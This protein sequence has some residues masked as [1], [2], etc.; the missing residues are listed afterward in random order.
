V[1]GGSLEDEEQ[2]TL[3]RLSTLFNPVRLFCIFLSELHYDHQVLLDYLISKDIG[4]S[5]AEYLLRLI[6]F[7]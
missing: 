3:F 4:A 5:C 2:I 6:L 7:S 1:E